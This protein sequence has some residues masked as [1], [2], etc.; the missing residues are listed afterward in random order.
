MRKISIK[1]ILL[2]LVTVSNAQNNNHFLKEITINLPD[3]IY[4]NANFNKQ[5]IKNVWKE[6]ESNPVKISEGYSDLI[7]RDYYYKYSRLY[8]DGECC[9]ELYYYGIDIKNSLFKIGYECQMQIKIFET[10]TTKI[11][12]VSSNYPASFA[13]PVV[14]YTIFYKYENGK[15]MDYT[16]EI[17]R[18]FNFATD[19]YSKE[20]IDWLN[21]HYQRNRYKEP[22]PKF[23]IYTF[24][25][26]DTIYIFEDFYDFAC[27]GDGDFYLDK[28]HILQELFWRAYV[29]KDCTLNP[30]GDVKKEKWD[31]TP[32]FE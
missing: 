18:G 6:Y 11:I 30:V 1:L 19:N 8:E 13:S 26:S 31:G 16:D 9:E 5:I 32:L 28:T 27:C 7:T 21:K 15:F 22:L 20:T 23:L 17:F 24:T 12:A 25:P 4:K 29:F 14:I 2:L 3:S 10:D